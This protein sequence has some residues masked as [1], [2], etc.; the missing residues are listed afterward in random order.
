MIA[1]AVS[2]SVAMMLETVEP[3]TGMNCWAIRY[4]FLFLIL[5]PYIN[6]NVC[7]PSVAGYV[8]VQGI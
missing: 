2:H 3:R 1:H 8:H 4:N 7:T 6:Y 5:R